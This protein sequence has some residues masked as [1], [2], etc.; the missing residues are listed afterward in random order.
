[1][2]TRAQHYRLSVKLTRRELDNPGGRCSYLT[3]LIGSR[4]RRRRRRRLFLRLRG[5]S[6]RLIGFFLLLLCVS[7]R[8]RGLG[9]L[10]S[11]REQQAESKEQG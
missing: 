3:G 1:M 2:Q 10:L 9:R 4:R 8:L 11:S 7:L 6:G 5:R